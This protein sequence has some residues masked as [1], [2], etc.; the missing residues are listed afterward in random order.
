LAVANVN[1]QQQ[2]NLQWPF[3]M[4]GNDRVVVGNNGSLSVPVPA[5]YFS[6]QPAIFMIDATTPA[7]EHASNFQ[8]VTVSNPASAGE[9]IAIYLTGLGDVNPRPAAGQAASANPLSFT[10]VV[11]TA[12]IGGLSASVLFSGLAPGFV[13]LYQVNLQ[14]P[15]NAPTGNL[16]LVIVEPVGSLFQSSP[17]VK[18]AV[19]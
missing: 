4:Q 9:V 10:V 11:P 18:V 8:P 12:T 6:A 5:R 19:R 1:G 15:A 3:D 17:A 2:I 14:V 7:I 16:D 13:G